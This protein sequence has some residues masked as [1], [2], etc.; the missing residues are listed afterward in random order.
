M[1]QPPEG[2]WPEPDATVVQTAPPVPPPPGPPRLA[3]EEPAPRRW[4]SLAGWLLAALFLAAAIILLF[5]WLNDRNKSSAAG[6]N[7][8]PNLVGEREAQAQTDA[9]N[10]GFNLTTVAHESGE[11]AGTVLDQAPDAG[12]A[13]EKGARVIAVVSAGKGEI[14]IPDLTGMKK[15]DA[16]TALKT[17]QLQVKVTETASDKPA[18]T[19]VAQSPTAGEHVAKNDVVAIVVSK[20][21][22]T[23][24]NGGTSTGNQVAVPT[25]VGMTEADA[26]TA[27][28][29]AK[30]IPEVHQV[31]SDQPRGQVTGQNPAS[32]EQVKPNSK[33]VINVSNGP[34]PTTKTTTV[35]QTV[36]QPS[37]AR[38]RTVTVTR[39]VTETQTVTVT[40]Q[41]PP[42]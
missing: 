41:Q 15:A 7:H 18:D 17:A 30:L 28:Q 8:V 2:D 20:G 25:V 38:T 6:T 33:V 32:G 5:L 1:T 21:G 23:S 27:L 40:T 22:K 16:L 11:P 19:V 24:T 37:G 12:A 29:Q 42:P 4:E 34:T 36:T 31:V 13:L 26:V 35:Q 14:T 9:Q 10:A 3:F 39:T